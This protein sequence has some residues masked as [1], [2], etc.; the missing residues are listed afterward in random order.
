MARTESVRSILQMGDR[1]TCELA[2]APLHRDSDR[3]RELGRPTLIRCPERPRARD[4]EGGE[5]GIKEGKFIKEGF[6]LYM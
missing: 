3:A 5:G 4:S 6:V 1:L 2:A